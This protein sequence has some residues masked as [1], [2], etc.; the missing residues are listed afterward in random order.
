M[1]ERHSHKPHC[2]KEAAVAGSKGGYEARNKEGNEYHDG[3]FR[4]A[5]PCRLHYTKDI[6]IVEIPEESQKHPP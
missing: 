5:T 4:G 1:S 3:R 2:R 6:P